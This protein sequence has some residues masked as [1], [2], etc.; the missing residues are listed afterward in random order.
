MPG[1]FLKNPNEFF[2]SKPLWDLCSSY[3]EVDPVGTAPPTYSNQ[4]NEAL[5]RD[6]GLSFE[7]P[8]V[9]LMPCQPHIPVALLRNWKVKTFHWRWSLALPMGRLTGKQFSFQQQTFK[10]KSIHPSKH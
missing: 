5:S 7:H 2:P 9:P 4:V 10:N 3:I 6:A 1:R 8:T